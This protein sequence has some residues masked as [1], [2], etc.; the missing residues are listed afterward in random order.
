[1][2]EYEVYIVRVWKQAS[3]LLLDSY[4]HNQ[5]AEWNSCECARTGIAD[6][7]I[8]IVYI[9]GSALIVQLHAPVTKALIARTQG[10]VREFN[11]ITRFVG[12]RARLLRK[13]VSFEESVGPP[14]LHVAVAAFST[15]AGARI[16]KKSE[17]H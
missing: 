13:L 14:P 5:A 8:G 6:R 10:G 7:A 16:K 1:V 11:F 2:I 3:A 9:V 4:M 12:R 15:L 17:T